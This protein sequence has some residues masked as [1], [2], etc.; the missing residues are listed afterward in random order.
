[1]LAHGVR[2]G[3]LMLKKGRGLSEKDIAAMVA[4]GIASVMVAEPEPG[5]VGEDEAARRLAA[6]IAGPNL[7]AKPP[8]TGRV[9]L[10]AAR[11]GLLLV[12]R[13]RLDRVNLVSESLTLATLEPFALVEADGMAATVKIIPFAV[14]EG[15]LSRCIE[16]AAGPEP[17]LRIAPLA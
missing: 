12:D 15:E 9:N 8:F 14:T 17:L 1:M 5:D 3:A 13:A 10:H 16:A 11:R 7:I 6:A 2:A 4:A